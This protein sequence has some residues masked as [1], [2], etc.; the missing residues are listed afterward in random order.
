ME[1]SLLTFDFSDIKQMPNMYICKPNDLTILGKIIDAYNINLN[2]K[3]GQINELSF[4]IP[5]YKEINHEIVKNP[6][7]DLLKNRYLIK[8]QYENFLEYFIID[9]PE[10]ISDDNSMTKNLSCYSYAY[11]LTDDI[12]TYSNEESYSQN[13]TEILNT[14]LIDTFWSVG[15][16]DASFDLMYRNFSFESK[17]CL[18]CCYDIATTFSAVITFDTINYKVNLYNLDNF[19]LDRGLTFN[20]GKYIKNISSKINTDNFATKLM[21]YGKDNLTIS[22]AN[23]TGSPYLL[24]YMY[25]IYPF[26]RHS[27]TGEVIKSSD[28]MSDGL[29]G[30]LLDYD[31]MISQ[32]QGEFSSLTSQKIDLREQVNTESEN[33]NTL[34]TQM[35]VI[36]DSLDIA[37]ANNL[38]TE[39]LLLQRDSKQEYIDNKKKEINSLLFDITIDTPCTSSGNILLYLNDIT[40]N[41]PLVSGDNTTA[42]ALKICDY[43]NNRYYNYDNKFPLNSTLKANYNANNIINIIHYT[44]EGKD[45]LYSYFVDT[46]NTGFTCTFSDNVNNGLENQI[47]NI[48]YQID[49]LTNLLSLEENFTEDELFELKKFTIK[50]EIRN[51]YISDVDQL[52]EWSKKSFED[53]YYPP[54]IL[55]LSIIDL[56]RTYDTGCQLEK[57]KVCIGENVKILYDQFNVNVSA[58]IIEL[59]LNFD[60]NEIN[61]TISSIKEISKDKDKFLKLINQS[62]STSVQ[63]D[64]NK[65]SWGGITSANNEI[66]NILDIFRGNIKNEINFNVNNSIQINERGIYIANELDPLKYIII[67]SGVIALT[68][69]GGN[70]WKTA[71]TPTHIVGDVIM[72]NLLCGINL[73]IDA[74]NGDGKQFFTVDE[75][76]FKIYNMILSIIREDEKMRVNIDGEN[77]IVIEKKNGSTWDNPIAMFSV[78]T[79]GVLNIRE[80]KILNT[81]GNTVLDISGENNEINFDNFLTKFGTVYADNLNINGIDI[82]DELSELRE[83]KTQI[84]ADGHIETMA[85]N[86]SQLFTKFGFNPNHIKRYPNKIWNSSFNSYNPITLLAYYWNGGQIEF[87]SSFDDTTSLRISPSGII[88]QEQIDGEGLPDSAWWNNQN[89]RY[90]LRKKGGSVKLSVHRLLDH[91]PLTIVNNYGETEISDSYLIFPSTEDWDDGYISFYCINPSST[92][93]QYLKIQNIDTVDA[94]IDAVQVEPDFTEYYPSFYTYGPK[95]YT[96]AEIN[97]TET[98]EYGNADYNNLGGI[99]FILVYAY[100]TMPVVTTDIAI[101]YNTNGD[102]GDELTGS[103]LRLVPVC[104]KDEISVNGT[105]TMLYSRIIV[106]CKGNNIPSSI[107]SGKITLKANCYG[108][109]SKT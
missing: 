78:D 51:D 23:I 83:I 1:N 59:D 89:S 82:R 56:F 25:F 61:L 35:L 45:I 34:N 74:S 5:Y 49:S 60:S 3:L 85:A 54:R 48:N 17:S 106:Y 26:E 8:F 6:I 55:E 93:K 30:S 24:N 69:D 10:D 87:N 15:Y 88:F 19:G 53:M 22:S 14:I 67:Q 72:G 38:D 43:I 108:R 12:V 33:L 32:H 86:N 58:K 80:L 105:P 71:I 16:I 9:V 94:Y 77:G 99:E 79:N 92:G 28:Y 97:S 64:A 96:T 103:D 90:S 73:K 20:Y 98:V 50:R 13:A 81:Q 44:T 36:L 4:S 63:L 41:I 91:T 102:I 47:T 84:T 21:V 31:S 52:Y 42:I 7:F 2:I 104:M 29:C 95:S 76:G 39:D 62:I 68:M 65:S 57:G 18:D 46:D 11:S 107:A 100:E 37:Q 40:M 66:A 70:T 101:D 109:V 27:E 75:T